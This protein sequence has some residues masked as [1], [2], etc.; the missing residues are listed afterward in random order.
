MESDFKVE[1]ILEILFDPIDIFFL[2]FKV[3]KII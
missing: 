1:D 2:I 3:I